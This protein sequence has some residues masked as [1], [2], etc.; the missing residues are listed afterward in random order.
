MRRASSV[1]GV[2]WPCEATQAQGASERAIRDAKRETEAVEATGGD[3]TSARLRLG[4]AQSDQ[5]S[6]LRENQWLRRRPSQESSYGL[7]RVYAL[8]SNRGTSVSE[9]FI[10]NKA[11]VGVE[12]FR[13][14]RKAVE[15]KGYHGLY[16]EGL[17]CKKNVGVTLLHNHPG[18]SDP[19]IADLRSASRPYVNSSVIACH[20]GSVIEFS[21]H[22]D[23]DEFDAVMERI[24]PIVRLDNPM[25]SD[26][27][28]IGS[29]A[30]DVFFEMNRSEGW[31][32][33][34]RS[35]VR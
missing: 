8:S 29:K 12:R 31:V 27:D 5:R 23:V 4:R 10:R 6:L 17:T 19:S 18:S 35:S 11:D 33:I 21:S 9:A 13:V 25:I 16:T 26:M 34:T 14:D 22:L 30:R 2:C 7:Y 15:G 32:T 20:D 1:K 3:A 28:E 24:T